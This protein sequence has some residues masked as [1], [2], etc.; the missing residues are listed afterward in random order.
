M[1]LF[2]NAEEAK[3]VVPQ[4]SG[5]VTNNS[6]GQ[7]T[8]LKGDVETHGILRMD[9][10]LIGN[11]QCHSK[12]FLGNDGQVE[13]DVFAQ[14]AEIEGEIHGKIEVAENLILRSSAVVHGDIITKS[15]TIDPGAVFN[16]Q[17]QMGKER[18]LLASST[19]SSSESISVE[20]KEA[21]KDEA[22]Q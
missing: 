14:N 3:K 9:G 4:Q 13:G 21:E 16:G 7:G 20:Q 17:C 1:G 10:K 6:I 8:T 5:N 11:L 2:G 18:P 15:L 12:L 19:A 22:T